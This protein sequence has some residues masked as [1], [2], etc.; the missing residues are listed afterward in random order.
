MPYKICNI[1][2]ARKA[3]GMFVIHVMLK[4]RSLRRQ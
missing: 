2:I 4:G 1:G 3:T